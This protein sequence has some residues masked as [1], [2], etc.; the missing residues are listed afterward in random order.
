MIASSTLE[1]VDAADAL[2]SQARDP[3]RGKNVICNYSGLE[4]AYGFLVNKLDSWFRANCAFASQA[5]ARPVCAGRGRAAVRTT[6]QPPGRCLQHSVGGG[7]RVRHVEYSD[8]GR[9]AFRAQ[10]PRIDVRRVDGGAC[11]AAVY[12]PAGLG[13]AGSIPHFPDK[14]SALN[15]IC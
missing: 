3:R 9:E 13:V 10:P 1:A 7:L 12:L 8:P 4:L 5:V 2:L 14:T 6:I 15:V 11:G